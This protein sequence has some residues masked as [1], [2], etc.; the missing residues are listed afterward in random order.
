MS[1][2]PIIEEEWPLPISI[3]DMPVGVADEEAMDIDMVMLAMLVGVE[4]A[5]SML[6]LEDMSIVVDLV[7]S[8]W[9]Q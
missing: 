3:P 9:R 2:M 6:M 4:D 5:M 1:D 8:L 7:R